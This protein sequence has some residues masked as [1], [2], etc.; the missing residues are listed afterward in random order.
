MSVI[1]DFLSGLDELPGRVDARR[2]KSVDILFERLIGFVV[3]K[4]RTACGIRGRR[5]G[6]SRWLGRRCSLALSHHVPDAKVEG[7]LRMRIVWVVRD[8]LIRSSALSTHVAWRESDGCEEIQIANFEC[9]CMASV[10]VGVSLGGDRE[11]Q[12]SS[13]TNPPL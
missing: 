3:V 2:Q 6:S 12:S 13:S 8:A 10:Q 1:D 9:Q 7:Y 4:M 11:C 5:C